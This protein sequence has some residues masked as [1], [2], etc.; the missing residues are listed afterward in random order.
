MEATYVRATIHTSFS[1]RKKLNYSYDLHDNG[2]R[3]VYIW[4]DASKYGTGDRVFYISDKYHEN[5]LFVKIW[6]ASIIKI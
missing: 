4:M 1:M 5:D 6:I 2:T 3:T